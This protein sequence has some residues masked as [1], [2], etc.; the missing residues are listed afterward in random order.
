VFEILGNFKKIGVFLR[1]LATLFIISF[2]LFNIFM[3]I[4]EQL[5]FI[6]PTN[7][8]R[9]DKYT[10]ITYSDASFT[11][12]NAGDYAGFS[13][14]G[15]G[16]VNGDGYDDILIGSWD[17]SPGNI[18]RGKVYL[19]FGKGPG[20]SMDIN[21]SKADASF[22]GEY[23]GDYAS[24]VDIAGD[25][26]GD[27][28]DDILIGAPNNKEGGVHPMDPGST[29]G[30]VYLI[31]GKASGWTHN[32]N[33]STAN[34]SFIGE[35]IID[36]VGHSIDGAGDVNGDGYDDILIG[37]MYN[38]ES[39]PVMSGQAYLIFG[40]ASGWSMDNNL[41]NSDAS[42]LGRK[43]YSE[44]GY[45]L[46]GVGDV[47]G[48]GLDDIMIGGI[49]ELPAGHLP[50][51]YLFYGKVAGWSMDTN[52]SKANAIFNE[53]THISTGAHSIA[54]VGDING[55]GL[56]DIIIGCEGN[57]NAGNRMGKSYV[58]F[59][60]T[61]NWSK[62]TPLSSI[63]VSFIGEND[64]DKSGGFVGGGGDVNGDGYNDFLISTSMFG[65][66]NNEVYLIL[67]KSSGWSNNTSLSLTDA[68][69]IYERR[70]DYSYGTNN[71]LIAGDVNADGFDDILIGI[72]M[73]DESGNDAGQV[74][75]IFPD[76]DLGPNVV[77]SV[78]VYSDPSFNDEID[79][80]EIGDTVYVELIGTDKNSSHFDNAAI[81]IS[82]D[83]SSPE[84]FW[85]YLLETGFNTG[86]YRGSFRIWD[87]THRHLKLINATIGENITISSVTDPTK[88]S[89]TLVS[90][91]V[92]LRPLLDETIAIED[93]EYF[94]HYWNYGFNSISAWTNG[95][96]ASWLNWDNVN[97]NLYG[98]PDNSDVG[99]Y[100][101]RINIT[102]GLGNFDE[103]YFEITVINTPPDITTEN[104]LI[105]FED[106]QYYIDYTSNDDDRGIITWHLKTNAIWLDIDP[107]LGV[108]SGT[109][110]ND[111]R[112]IYWV[113]VSVHDGNDGTDWSYFEIMV[114][115][116]N[117]PPI[118]TTE[119][120][121][122]TYEDKLY[123]VIYNATD[124]D[125]DKIFE[126]Y[127]DTNA[128]W[129]S[130]DKTSGKLY[131][132]PMNPD[133]GIS[134]VNVTVSDLRTGSDSQN[135]TLEVINVNDPPVWVT[136]PEDSKVNEGDLYIF[137]VNATD[138]DS[139]EIPTYQIHT[140]PETDITI[141]SI[142]GVIE[143]YATIEN[144]SLPQYIINV[145][146]Y[147]T[148]GKTTISNSFEITI[149][150][151]P[152]PITHLQE[153][154]DSSI[155]STIGTKLKWIGYDE[156]DEQLTFDI[157]LDKDLL[158]V[159]DLLSNVRIAHNIKNNSYFIKN[160]NAGSKYYWT[161]IP[162][163]G[164]RYGECVDSFFSFEVNSPPKLS[165]ISQQ[166]ARVGYEF[167]L[168][169]EASDTNPTDIKNL[170]FSLENAPEGMAVDPISGIITW[171]PTK[172]QIGS[173]TFKVWISDG[174]DQT[175][176]S[177]EI[178]VTE[179]KIE[180][181][182]SMPIVVTT[183][184][185]ILI[186]IILT[187]FISGTEVGKYRFLSMVYVPLYNRLHP[188]KVFDNYTRG[189]I[190]GYIKAKPGEHYNA[191]KSALK[192]KN[193]T[194][195]HHTK[196]LEKEGIISIRRDGLFTRFYPSGTRASEMELPTLIETQ[197]E[198]ID[199][200]RH[201]PGITQHEI[202]DFIGIS[203]TTVSRNLLYLE[204][205]NLIKVE[206]QKRE[207]RYYINEETL[208]SLK[209]LTKSETGRSDQSTSSE[210]KI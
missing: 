154:A 156:Y 108:V 57:P 50:H 47:N 210:L 192:L 63:N 2:L 18:S 189:Q 139:G 38:N 24:Y 79:I 159:S 17:S 181:K 56:D 116:T 69:F 167:T 174:I 45:S 140:V 12:E 123:S 30:Q 48:D 202:M 179:K 206:K 124:I 35:T 113:N 171:L 141:D 173:H 98:T 208:E 102:D 95:T 186:I 65:R 103:H 150:R 148:D 104:I 151:N 204:R 43:N 147:A 8:L 6:K 1:K 143:W 164:L 201:Q 46:A 158:S 111:D 182:L 19:I 142:T 37:S 89:K 3:I 153:P 184:F 84:G 178:Q 90:I 9:F 49:R 198:I 66:R 191:I 187:S 193:G 161:V 53:K 58:I 144:L 199:T 169:L 94:M 60:Q 115:D 163:D 183:T 120:V 92:Q 51:A 209:Q 21:I 33:V 172:E 195:T 130:I 97:H 101:V 13:I 146:I 176:S 91:S 59:G 15:G 83:I 55:D 72:S 81:N 205:K 121:T 203:Q 5:S 34:A 25:I 157:Y 62:K 145:V 132:T 160:L 168:V 71:I 133:V 175:N 54:G 152:L 22:V 109:P 41:S 122:V 96:N 52:I 112:G 27:G 110:T 155:V 126:W 170:E 29:A 26:N 36:Y 70:V 4:P 75:L 64:W 32:T 128:T 10:N 40:K 185:F 194:L 88:Y 7:A 149:I 162:Y 80:V 14:A 118:I 137:D 190:H 67:G 180:S 77:N 39:A 76:L 61:T 93:E 200:I 134:Y 196:I 78:K 131:G 177:F 87:R 85:F 129:L 100:W 138:P 44:V 23:P 114:L 20:W 86:K 11:G 197:Q 99:T 73:N 74:Y 135:F 188:K 165:R 107:F 16:D 136:V 106:E 119:N 127:L 31:F 28:F 125:G 82:S 68:S 166:N 207:H 105:A 42:F 117:D